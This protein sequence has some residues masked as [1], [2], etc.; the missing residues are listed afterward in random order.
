[1]GRG[2]C[3]FLRSVPDLIQGRPLGER[4]GGVPARS[5]PLISLPVPVRT[6]APF[7]PEGRGGGKIQTEFGRMLGLS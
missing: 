4:A 3:S 6:P 7:C 1:M 5:G 2:L